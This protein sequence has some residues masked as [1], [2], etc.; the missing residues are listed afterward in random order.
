MLI[1]HLTVGVSDHWCAVV[2][3]PNRLYVRRENKR[4]PCN[5]IT[6]SWD[7]ALGGGGGSGLSTLEKRISS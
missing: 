5:S 7:L 4:A 3:Q 2:G 1:D 6:F